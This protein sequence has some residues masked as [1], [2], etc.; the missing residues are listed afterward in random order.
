MSANVFSSH[1]ETSGI[2]VPT[3]RRGGLPGLRNTG[4]I[5][6]RASTHNNYLTVAGDLVLML[7]T[8]THWHLDVGK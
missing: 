6:K 1:A 2:V 4:Q 8:T 5:A 3:S 7:S